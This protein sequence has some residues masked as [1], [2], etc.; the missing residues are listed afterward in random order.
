MD[1][2]EDLEALRA[3]Y[4]T[5]ADGSTPTQAEAEAKV[6]FR[7]TLTKFLSR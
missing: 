2:D 4:G 3:V 6:S 7:P 1:E 5:G